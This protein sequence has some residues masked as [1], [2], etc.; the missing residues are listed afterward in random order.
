MTEGL[1][2]I[3]TTAARKVLVISGV[4]PP[5]RIAEADHVLHIS[6][7]LAERDFAIEVLTRQ[8]SVEDA[9]RN[10]VVQPAMST[11]R[12]AELP[13]LVAA[14]KRYS[15]D[16][17]FLWFLGHAY[18]FHPMVTFVPTVLKRVLPGTAVVTQIT[19]PVGYWPQRHSFLTKLSRKAAAIAAG[20]GGVD[21]SLGTL[22]RDSDQII[23]M[24]ET[25]LSDIAQRWPQAAGKSTLISPPPLLPMSPATTESRMRGRQALGL[26]SD[27]FVFAYFGRLYRGKGLET[28]LHAFHKLCAS[29]SNVKLAIIGG[30]PEIESGTDK[31]SYDDWRVDRLYEL[32]RALQVDNGVVWTGEY[33][34]DSDLGSIY[35]RAAD[36]AVLP[37]D[38]GVHL[39]NSSFAGV[40]AH[41]LPTITTRG[42]DL[43]IPFL[44]GENV[45]LCPPTDAGAVAAAMERLLL[46]AGLRARLRGGIESLANE[47]FSW[48]SSID[49]TIAVFDAAASRAPRPDI[50][51]VP[52]GA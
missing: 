49:R 32:A 26:S 46:D 10:I 18:D 31:S 12:W 38:S 8:G 30:A 24:A 11:W 20:S 17:V 42:V 45:L 6:R 16:I 7:R 29:H 5:A 39:N 33:P 43:E 40:A 21:Y 48:D 36:V 51:A 35:L 19:I 25:H 3:M 27:D 44:D 15:P 14:A 4:F 9:G 23:V 50:Q 41:G 22:L 47:R 13:R 28:L 52:M 2:Q 34:W 37:F 1:P